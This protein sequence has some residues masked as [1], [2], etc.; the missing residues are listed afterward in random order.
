MKLFDF[1]FQAGNLMEWNVETNIQRIL[2]S[3]E[4][5]AFVSKTST[6]VAF[7]DNNQH[8]VPIQ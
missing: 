8:L 3:N 1:R 7:A 2:V 6:F 5:L 4:T